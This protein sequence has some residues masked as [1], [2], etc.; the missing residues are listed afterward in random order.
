VYSTQRHQG[1]V[2]CPRQTRGTAAELSTPSA[3]S[4]TNAKSTTEGSRRI[5][6]E[7]TVGSYVKTGNFTDFNPIFEALR[8]CATL[9]NI[10]WNLF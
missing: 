7:K 3:C 9:Q 6:A 5:A 8:V 1:G 10:N 4:R 2:V